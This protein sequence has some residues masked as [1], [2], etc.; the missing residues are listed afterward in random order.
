VAKRGT[1]RIRLETALNAVETPVFVI[2]A[3]RRVVFVNQGCE[4]LTGWTAV[5]TVG[6]VCDFASSAEPTVV[7]SLTQSLCPPPEVFEGTATQTPRYFVNR[8]SLQSSARLVHFFPL[9]DSDRSTFILGVVTGVPSARQPTGTS[10]IASVHAELAALRHDLRERFDISSFVCHSPIMQRVLEQVHLARQS[11]A[12]VHFTGQ[13]GTGKEHAARSIHYVGPSGQ[14]S[15]VPLNCRQLPPSELRESLRRLVETDWADVSTASALQ[16]GTVF[17]NHVEGLPR[18][19]QQRIL[20]FI[21]SRHGAAFRNQVRLMTASSVDLNQLR[22]DESLTEEFYFL[23]TALQIELPPLAHRTGDLHVLAQHFLE[24]RN[25][26][27]GQQISGFTDEVNSLFEHYNWPG[28][29]DEL[30]QVVSEAHAA[31]AG[32]VI[33]TDHL[34]F[35][36]RTGLD[37]QSLGP[38]PTGRVEPLEQLLTRIEREHI[39]NALELA[40]GN[41]AQAARLLGLTRPALYRRLESL[42]LGE[43]NS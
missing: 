30:E 15:F 11:N 37:A 20:D 39:V 22:D 41:K 43:E 23:V 2:D 24:Q 1:R 36:F 28:N 38:P 27:S 7:E 14:R 19:L 12:I 35:R 3:Q 32:S 25:H 18:D 21:P 31:C 29:L 16:P 40:G 34:P 4:L 5:E 17:L 26:G 10:V 42:G 33:G 8:N 9:D 6:R 13:S